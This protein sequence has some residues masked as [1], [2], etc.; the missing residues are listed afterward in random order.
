[1][2]HLLVIESWVGPS[3]VS[4]PL[5]IR[6]LGHRFTFVTRNPEHYRAAS[7]VAGPHPLLQADRILTTETNDLSNLISFVQDAHQSDPFDGVLTSCDYYLESVAEVAS[8]LVLPTTTPGGVRVARTKHLARAALTEAGLPN[9]MF[10]VATSWDEARVAAERIG[11]PLVLKPVDL[12]AG[13]YVRLVSDEAELRQGVEALEGLPR[14]AR[15]QPRSTCYLLE[16]FL[17]GDEVSVETASFNGHAHVLGITDKTIGGWPAFIEQGHMFPA[18]LDPTQAEATLDLVRKALQA[19]G[20]DHG[21]AHTE[22]K[23]TPHGPRIVEINARLG[24]NYI[25]DLVRAVAG[26]DIPQIMVQLALGEQPAVQPVTTGVRSA[27]VR[28]FLPE[29]AGKIGEVTGAETLA[30]DRRVL[31]W[32]LQAHPGQVVRRPADNSDYLGRVIVA[33]RDG[34]NARE[35]AEQVAGHV[36]IPVRVGEPA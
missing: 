35:L 26:L 5:A 8:R 31:D 32:E 29:C 33:D 14:N 9:P 23:L 18:R 34:P 2:A 1:M 36:R 28:F 27:A 10:A 20:Y 30:A 4:L 7:P 19:V 13:M 16:E 17:V 15:Q 12:C 6:Q 11:Y 3:S 25:P 21:V 24:G 22:V